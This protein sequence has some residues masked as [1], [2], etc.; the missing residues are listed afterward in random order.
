MVDVPLLVAI[1]MSMTPAAWAGTVAAI[2]VAEFTVK[3]VAFVPPKVT[4]VAPVKLLPVMVTDV[5]PAV[6]PAEGLTPVIA[7][8]GTL[9]VNWSADDVLEVPLEFET[10]I[11]TSPEECIGD[12]AVIWVAEFTVKLDALVPPK[13]TELAPVKLLPVMMTEVPPVVGPDVRLMPETVGA[14]AG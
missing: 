12:V 2:C 6:D 4:L 10:V 7:G 9:K 8:P 11:S 3:L 5:P 14:D 13:E 1:A